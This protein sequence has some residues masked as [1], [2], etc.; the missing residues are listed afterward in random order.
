VIGR[1]DLPKRHTIQPEGSYVQS[2]GGTRY[3]IEVEPHKYDIEQKFP[4]VRDDVYLVDA[5]RV[6]VRKWANGIWKLHFVVVETGEKS[7]TIEMLIRFW[8]FHYNP[9]VHGPPN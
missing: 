8:T 3:G 4:Y 7:S 9:I 1:P 5:N 6:R 2:P